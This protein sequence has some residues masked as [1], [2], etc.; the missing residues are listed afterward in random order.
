M[1]ATTLNI[2]TSQDAI[3]EAVAGQ[4]KFF[5]SKATLPLSFRMQQLKKLK[6]LLEQNEAALF[7]AIKKDFGKSKNDTLMTELLP[8]KHEIDLGI[9]NLK[10]W[11]KPKRVRTNLL[12]MP[13][14]S[15]LVAEPLGTALIIGAWNFPYNL[16]LSPLVSSMLAGNVSIL[17]PSEVAPATSQIMAKLINNNFDPNYIKVIEGGVPETT[18]LLEQR[19]DKV[20]YTGSPRVGKI[21]NQAV[22]KHLTNVT[23]ELG[24]KNPV[25][26]TQ[27]CE[28]E[29]SV[30]RMVWAKFVNAGQFCIAPDYVLVPKSRKAEFLEVLVK[31]IKKHSYSLEK[32]NYVQIINERNFERVANLIDPEKVFFGGKMDKAKRLIQPTVLDNVSLEDKVMEEEIFG[33]VLPV[34]AYDQIDEAFEIV[35]QFEKPLGAYLFTNDS[36]IKQRFLRE[37]PF[38]GGGINEAS[39]HVTNSNLPFGGV[40]NSGIGSYHGKFGFDCFSHQ[41][42]VIDKPTFIELDFKYYGLNDL[43]M[44]IARKFF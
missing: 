44:K 37:V 17:K 38:G 22:A 12:N 11:A 29:V 25:I 4:R 15:Y 19:F 8:L 26:F 13:A 5:K 41:K 20:F 23:L 3:V 40:G 34:L 36:K 7:A 33:P 43:K 24:G 28:L 30:K 6:S 2:E 10:Q 35:A 14:K 1:S 9:K 32:G 18:A 21:V 42:A 16:A 27:D 31:E 39:M